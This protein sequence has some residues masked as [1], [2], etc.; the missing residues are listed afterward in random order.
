[1]D[2]NSIVSSAIS[3]NTQQKVGDAVGTKVASKALDIQVETAAAL[4]SS[5]SS[6]SKPAASE[7]HLGNTINTHA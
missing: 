4:I 7:T 2:I 1:M 3:Q 6:V 5:V